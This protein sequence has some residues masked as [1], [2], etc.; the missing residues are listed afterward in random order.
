MKKVKIINTVTLLSDLGLKENKYV[1][2]DEDA[3]V[4]NCS[5]NTVLKYASDN[6]LDLLT[7][8]SYPTGEVNLFQLVR[9]LRNVADIKEILFKKPV[10]RFDPSRRL[11]NINAPITR[12]G[13]NHENN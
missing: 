3:F 9:H 8:F 5:V 6:R 4:L 11:E 7:K 2:M 12:I 10:W 13:W 1:Q